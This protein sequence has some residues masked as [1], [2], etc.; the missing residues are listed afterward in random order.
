VI[1]QQ[2]LGALSPLGA[3]VGIGTEGEISPPPNMHTIAKGPM[4]WIVFILPGET[5]RTARVMSLWKVGKAEGWTGYIE[6]SGVRYFLSADETAYVV[7]TSGT[8]NP[9]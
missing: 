6:R 2:A 5:A 3:Q 1:A 8:L 9:R 7:S 4:C